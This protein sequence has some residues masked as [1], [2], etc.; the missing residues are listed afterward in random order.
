MA[1]VEPKRDIEGIDDALRAVLGIVAAG[2][3]FEQHGEF[4]AADARHGV[5]LADDLLQALRGGAQDAVAG[6]VAQRVVDVLEAIQVE[7]QQRHA[8]ALAA[9]ADDRAG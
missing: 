9:R 8:R 7:E 5:A 3:V 6:G 2:E 4:V 1:V